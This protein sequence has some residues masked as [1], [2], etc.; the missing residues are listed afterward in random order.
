MGTGYSKDEVI[1]TQAGNS[2]GVTT[3]AGKFELSELIGV[4]IGGVFIGLV[5]MGI[6]WCICKLGKKK[7]RAEMRR[8][9]TRSMYE[10]RNS[11]SAV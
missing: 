9:I 4:L 1:I 6:V 2:G 3:G 11:E 5:I 8:Q 10:L 7:L